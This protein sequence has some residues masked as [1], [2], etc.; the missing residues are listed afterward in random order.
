MYL[1]IDSEVNFTCSFCNTYICNY[2]FSVA[3]KMLCTPWPR[4]P[5]TSPRLAAS[6]ASG[7]SDNFSLGKLKN[8]FAALTYK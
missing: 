5:L 7:L 6:A 3:Q 2:K 8:D 1:F 4:N